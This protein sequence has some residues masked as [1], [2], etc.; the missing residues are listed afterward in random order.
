LLRLQEEIRKLVEKEFGTILAR[1]GFGLPIY[2][3]GLKAL[4]EGR[5]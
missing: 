3:K 5:A 2:A 4:F 1:A